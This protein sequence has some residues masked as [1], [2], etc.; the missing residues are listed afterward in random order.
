LIE[1]APR[2]VKRAALSQQ[3]AK[4]KVGPV[5]DG[6]KQR[7]IDRSARDRGDS[8]QPLYRVSDPA[9]ETISLLVRFSVSVLEIQ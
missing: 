1:R 4:V 2:G 7:V 6:G 8:D 9:I 5:R 3:F